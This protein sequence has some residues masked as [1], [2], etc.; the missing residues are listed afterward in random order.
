MT[1]EIENL[2]GRMPL[3]KP[4]ASLDDR[5]IGRRRRRRILAWSLASGAVAA[6]A[7]AVVVAVLLTT[8][9]DGTMVARSPNPPAVPNVPV[10][11]V[12]QA[13]SPKPLRLERN[14]AAVSYEGVVAPDEGA[15]LMKF[16]R[17]TLGHVQMIDQARGR[18]MEMTV[19]GEEVI[20]IK[21][22]V[23]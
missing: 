10:E 4:P 15:P 20:L 6:A 18:Q 11:R 1:N 19:P 17:R 16:R 14:W 13:P 2:L 21:A 22:P 5:V 23:D 7:A 9:P 8:G 3:R 12:A